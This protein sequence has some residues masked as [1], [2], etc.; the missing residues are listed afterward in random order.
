[1]KEKL[2]SE[3]YIQRGDRLIILVERASACG[4]ILYCFKK[5]LCLYVPL[6]QRRVCRSVEVGSDFLF[7]AS[8]WLLRALQLT[9]YGQHGLV[10][11][12]V[13]SRPFS[14]DPFMLVFYKLQV[15]N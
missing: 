1:M 4:K 6:Q 11:M 7:L 5:W 13:K 10:E 12:E 2:W 3:F 9:V 14:L 15:Q 8:A